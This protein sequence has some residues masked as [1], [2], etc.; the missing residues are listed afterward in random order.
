M[1]GRTLSRFSLG[2]FLGSAKRPVAIDF[3]TS[4]LKVLQLSDDTPATIL[5]AVSLPT[6]SNLINDGPKRFAFQAEQLPGLLK[7]AGISGQRAV[8]SIPNWACSVRHLQVGGVDQYNAASMTASMLASELNCEPGALMCRPVVVHGANAG[9]ATGSGKAEIIAMATGVGIVQRIMDVMRASRMKCVGIQPTASALTSAFEY[10]TARDSD[11]SLVSLYVDLGGASTTVTIAHGRELC[12]AKT[13]DLG[14][15]FIDQ[16][17]AHA[18]QCT[19]TEAMERRLQRAQQYSMAPVA[20]AA[21]A[22]RSM[23]PS[24]PMTGGAMPHMDA[25]MNLAKAGSAIAE[26]RRTAQ[27]PTGCA[28]PEGEIDRELAEPLGVIEDEIRLC[29]R[30]HDALFPGIKI[31]R[32]VFCGGEAR[33]TGLCQHIAKALRLPAHVADPL[34]RFARKARPSPNAVDLAKPQPGW[35][36]CAGLATGPTDL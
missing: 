28:T 29:L 3:G 12:F 31:G 2:G 26:E 16:T 6:P 33:H 25:A 23:T 5:A 19:V 1:F 8:A 11:A 13:I 18:T 21:P 35:A 30:Y 10:M 22:P 9:G 17:V 20:G 14:G 15:N 24:K 4:S 27:P 34:A 32:A 36:V 7:S